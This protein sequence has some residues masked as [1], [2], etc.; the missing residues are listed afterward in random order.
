MLARHIAKF[1]ETIT[2]FGQRC[3]QQTLATSDMKP[4]TRHKHISVA[5][6]VLVLISPHTPA[7]AGK[8]GK[9]FGEAN[10]HIFSYSSQAILLEF[11]LAF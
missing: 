11:D 6:L 2:N 10:R 7:L 1:L 4:I 8:G 9:W 3:I 5:A